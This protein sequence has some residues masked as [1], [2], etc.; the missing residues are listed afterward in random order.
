[1]QVRRLPVVSRDNFLVGIVAL[2]DL[3][4]DAADEAG[5]ALGKISMHGGDHSSLDK[6]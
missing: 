3:A 4:I 1:M 5:D 2:G 6:H